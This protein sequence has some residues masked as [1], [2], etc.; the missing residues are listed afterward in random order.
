M[1]LHP[2]PPSQSSQL[3]AQIA[4]SSP[5]NPNYGF[6][7][8]ES[9]QMEHN[10]YTNLSPIYDPGMMY[11]KVAGGNMAENPISRKRGR[12]EDLGLSSGIKAKT[13]T[14]LRLST[15]EMNENNGCSSSL[16]GGLSIRMQREQHELDLFVLMQM[17]KIRVELEQKRRNYW[18]NVFQVVEEGM[19]RILK[20]KDEEIDKMSRRNTALEEKVKSLLLEGQIWKTVAQTN[21]ATVTLLRRDLELVQ[22]REG[23]GDNGEVDDSTSCCDGQ[24]AI[25]RNC[26]GC[27]KNEI[28]VL[29]LPCRHLCLCSECDPRFESC[30]MCMLP[31]SASI[32]VHMC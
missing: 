18:S 12:E 17:E 10:F 6:P 2:Q 3:M 21:E 4:S 24:K 26:Q 23:E 14:G 8:C 30:P 5:S 20:G 28:S 27:G 1:F 25:S 11:N 31:K 22:T 9:L 15:D 32:K 13:S 19:Q 29:A 16:S 7:F